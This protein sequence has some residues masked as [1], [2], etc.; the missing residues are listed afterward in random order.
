MYEI[1]VKVP[2]LLD[3]E[4]GPIRDAAESCRERL[5]SLGAQ[6]I[7]RR[8]QTD[9]Y[10]QHPNVDF[11]LTDEAFRIRCQEWRGENRR[12]IRLTYK[13]PRVSE[14]TKARIEQELSLGPNVT[15]EGAL[16]LLGSLGFTLSAEVSKERWTYDFLKMV[17]CIDIVPELG[18]FMEVEM[19][20]E[21]IE[22]GEEQILAFLEENGWS[23]VE[24]RSYL[25]LL[26][27][28]QS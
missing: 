3:T 4:I 14:R 23:E 10:L 2:L 9:L 7:D 26:E 27:G 12:D 15:R 20:G 24:N 19:K 13:G 28:G 8:L 17:L 6:E 5:L 11:R 21:N 25:E 1:E 18:A 22:E 16:S